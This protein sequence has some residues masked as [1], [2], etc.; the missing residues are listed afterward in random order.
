MSKPRKSTVDELV[1]T[2]DRFD[3]DVQE[4]V[5]DQ[6]ELVHRLTKRRAKEVPPLRAHGV[7]TPGQPAATLL[8]GQPESEAM[9]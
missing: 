7:T 6:L 5:L 8:D 2:F 9:R 3:V 1:D 4:R